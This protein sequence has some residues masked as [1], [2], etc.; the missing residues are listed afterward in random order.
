MVDDFVEFLFKIQVVCFVVD[1]V[2]QQQGCFVGIFVV[3]EDLGGDFY[4]VCGI[5]EMLGVEFVDQKEFDFVVMCNDDYVGGCIDEGGDL[6]F[7]EF[8]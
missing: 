2:G 4:I 3:G 6:I 5:V 7:F 1:F 8:W